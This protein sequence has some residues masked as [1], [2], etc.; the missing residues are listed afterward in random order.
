MLKSFARPNTDVGHPADI[1]FFEKHPHRKYRLRRASEI[2]ASRATIFSLSDLHWDKIPG[3]LPLVVIER[4]APLM[5]TTYLFQGKS[6]SPLARLGDA[7]LKALCDAIKFKRV[8]ST[9]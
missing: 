3:H 2:E 8:S 5:H 7:D 1:E 9:Y 4:T 6:N